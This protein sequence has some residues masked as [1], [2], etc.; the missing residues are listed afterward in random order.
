MH[1]NIYQRS[2]Q[3]TKDKIFSLTVQWSDPA[4]LEPAVISLVLYSFAK[5]RA[6]IGQKKETSLSF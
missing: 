4:L 2:V 3:K 6:Y 5:Q 1:E